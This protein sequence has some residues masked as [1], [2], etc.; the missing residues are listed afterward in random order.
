M[1]QRA[2]LPTTSGDQMRPR[3]LAQRQAMR[4]TTTRVHDVDPGSSQRVVRDEAGAS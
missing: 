3:D 1:G 2:N 4:A